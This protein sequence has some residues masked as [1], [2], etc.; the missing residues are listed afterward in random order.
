MYWIRTCAVEADPSMPLHTFRH[1]EEQQTLLHIDLLTA[2][3]VAVRGE[4]VADHED[5]CRLARARGLV[6]REQHLG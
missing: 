6:G 1:R 2:R 5:R 4:R 3:V